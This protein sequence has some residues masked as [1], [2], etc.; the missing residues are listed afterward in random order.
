MIP[1][2]LG[3][4][5][6]TILIEQAV[7]RLLTEWDRKSAL[8]SVGMNVLTN[9]PLNLIVF[10]VDDSWLTIL[11]GEVLVIIIEALLYFR[12]KKPLSRAFIISMLCNATSYFTGLL[13]TLILQFMAF[14]T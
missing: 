14:Q 11:A 1:S 8:A 7:L 13:F 6:F 12:Y 9:V 4:L 3:A 5:L 2:L 10:W